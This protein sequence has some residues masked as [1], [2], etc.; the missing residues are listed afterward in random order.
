MEEKT[1]FPL[2]LGGGGGDCNK[3]CSAYKLV[4]EEC[5]KD[6]LKAVYEGETG[7]N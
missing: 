1:V 4:C 6:N 3:S 7:R 2:P 5:T